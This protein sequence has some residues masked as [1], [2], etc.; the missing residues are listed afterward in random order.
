MEVLFDIPIVP[1]AYKHLLDHATII[2]A[3]IM[4]GYGFTL[5]RGILNEYGMLVKKM[6]KGEKI[7]E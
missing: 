3:F 2:F 4:I 1:L 5:M 6:R 7:S